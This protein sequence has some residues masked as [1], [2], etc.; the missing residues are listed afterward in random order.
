MGNSED[1]TDELTDSEL[2]IAV[3]EAIKSYRKG[4]K[5]SQSEL[6]NLSGLDRNTI[7]KIENGKSNLSYITLYKIVTALN[8]PS[9]T[10]FDFG[11]KSPESQLRQMILME[12]Y[13]CDEQE[14]DHL[15]RI[16]SLQKT[17]LREIKKS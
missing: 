8:M 3:G 13:D 11:I 14:M 9:N 10:L 4:K 7:S 2:K 15:Y 6:C 1:R 17:L 16:L 5:I 12:L